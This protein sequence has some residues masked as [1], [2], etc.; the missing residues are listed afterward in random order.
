MKILR[1]LI[2]FLLIVNWGCTV[3][4]PEIPEG[5]S[6][7]EKGGEP[8]A[9]ASVQELSQNSVILKTDIESTGGRKL[10]RFCA[11]YSETNSLPDTTD[12]VTDLFIQYQPDAEELLISLSDLEPATSYYCRLYLA[13]PDSGS[14]T[15]S[16][17]FSTKVPSDNTSW[18]KV[19]S[20]PYM[21]AFYLT[22][23]NAGDRFFAVASYASSAD[24][25]NLIEYLP[26]TDE[27]IKRSALPFGR[28]LEPVAVSAGGKGYAGLGDI[29]VVGE[30]GSHH[31]Y[32][33]QDWWCYDPATDG[34]ERKAD[35][36]ASTTGMMAAFGIGD[37]IYVLT[38]ADNWN[39]TPMLVLEYD[40][41]SDTWTRRKDFPGEK[42]MHAASFVINGR[43][44]VFTGATNRMEEGGNVDDNKPEY[45]S[46][47]WEY[48]VETDTW[49]RR[50]DFK[51]G[52]RESMVAAALDGKGYAG[53]GIQ[54]VTDT[55]LVQAVD[56]WV[57]DP[58]KDLWSRRSV[59]QDWW[60]SQFG[61]AFSI[62]GHI[63]VGGIYDGVWK[64]VE[65]D[66]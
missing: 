7:Y 5:H 63:Y 65:K 20:I 19:A 59:H 37:K 50:Q 17:V 21:S 9:R 11:C 1:H 58:D 49:H 34:W 54:P 38:S 61:L 39:S 56:W 42:L 66:R 16:V 25:N 44:F 48:E 23:F 26:E 36:P 27:W 41:R 35:I 4:D 18:Q 45:T 10:T 29:E 47:M 30:E 60:N 13:N 32:F 12:R 22:G 57:Y 2:S 15:N 14:Y 33:Q 53:F 55:Y 51:G 3:T 8:K 43:P 28:R 31:Y 46:K 6:T 62:K 64:Y 24:G 52:G 40:T